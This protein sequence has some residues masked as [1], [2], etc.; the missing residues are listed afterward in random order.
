M[1]GFSFADFADLESRQTTMADLTAFVSTPQILVVDGQARTG[2]GELVGRHY[3][4][5]LRLR[6]A[7]GGR[8]NRVTMSQTQR[9]SP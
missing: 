2:L 7:L 4:E 3:F 1:V 6:P 5:T 8:S 9:P